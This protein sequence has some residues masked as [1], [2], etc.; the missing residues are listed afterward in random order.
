MQVYEPSTSIVQEKPEYTNIEN[1][2]GIFSARYWKPQSKKL[3]SDAIANL[4]DLD[5]K[6]EH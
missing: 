6:F 4:K 3:H 2:I 5:L 1:G